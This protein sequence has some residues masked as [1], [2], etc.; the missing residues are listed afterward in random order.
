[1]LLKQMSHAHEAHGSIWQGDKH[2]PLFEVI[3][4]ECTDTYKQA[5]PDL[6]LSRV[7]VGF[8]GALVTLSIKI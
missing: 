1:M 7:G 5:M 3:T 8:L 6:E 4:L 2:V